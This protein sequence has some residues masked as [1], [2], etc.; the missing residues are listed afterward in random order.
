MNKDTRIDIFVIGIFCI[1]GAIKKN[2]F[3]EKTPLEMNESMTE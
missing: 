1:Q 2:Y 3:A